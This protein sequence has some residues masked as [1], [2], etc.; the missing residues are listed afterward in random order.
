MITHSATLRDYLPSF[1][2]SMVIGFVVSGP[3][4]LHFSRSE[5]I[6]NIYYMQQ[7]YDAC[8]S[9]RSPV[10]HV[11]LGTFEIYADPEGEYRFRLRAPDGEIVA[12][13]EGYAEKSSCRSGIERIKRYAPAAIIA[14]IRG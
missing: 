13:S 12:V 11:T 10:E 4:I 6:H 14:E 2:L 8:G 3:E 5:N 7:Y 1:F 9:L